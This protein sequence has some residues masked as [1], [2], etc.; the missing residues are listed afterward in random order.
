MESR[1]NIVLPFD[2]RGNGDEWLYSGYLNVVPTWFIYGSG[3]RYKR[4]KDVI[5]D[6]MII[7]FLHFPLPT[8]SLFFS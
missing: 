4:K 1:T 5:S 6:S 8:S 7:L 2:H 3:I